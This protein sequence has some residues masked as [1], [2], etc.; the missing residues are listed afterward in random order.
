MLFLAYP[1]IFLLQKWFLQTAC[2]HVMTA[3]SELD[4][5]HGGGNQEPAFSVPTLFS[6][7]FPL[8]IQ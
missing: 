8:Y 3:Y 4:L 2:Q 6:I 7:H 1:H 5:T